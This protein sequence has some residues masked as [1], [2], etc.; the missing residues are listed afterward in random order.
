MTPSPTRGPHAVYT[1]RTTSWPSVVAASA[2]AVLVV[3]MGQQSRGAWTDP[4]FVG[5]MVFVTVGI[6]FTILTAS[7]IRVTAGPNGFST[8]WGPV[9][10]PRFSYGID[11]IEHCDVID[12]PWWTV[13]Y[14]AWW[15]PKRTNCT[16]RSGAALRLTLRNRRTVV[17]TVPDPEQAVIAIQ[18]GRRDRTV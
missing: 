5:P 2:G 4:S 9:G 15:T 6:L 16:V 11:E 8:Q 17:V 10:W 13:S 3:M 14:G 1:G 12:V 18:Q 7:S